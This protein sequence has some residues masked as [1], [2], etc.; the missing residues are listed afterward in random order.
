VEVTWDDPRS[1]HDSFTIDD[2][3]Q[4]KGVG[5]QRNRKTGGYLCYFNEEWLEL[6][7]DL[8]EGDREVGGGTAILWV[9]VTRVKRVSN[10]KVLY[11]RQV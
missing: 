7:S 1:I 4:G 2:V 11:A 10:G 5:L 6:Y 9:L 8:D 3:L